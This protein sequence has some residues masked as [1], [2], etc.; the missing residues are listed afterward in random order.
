MIMI[1]FVFRILFFAIISNIYLDNIA[2]RVSGFFS[3]FIFILKKHIIF[4][5]LLFSYISLYIFFKQSSSWF[6]I[7]IY[8][9]YYYLL[10]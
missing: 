1:F 6:G 8:T 2:L 3:L 7:I 5:I 4:K 10:F 9:T